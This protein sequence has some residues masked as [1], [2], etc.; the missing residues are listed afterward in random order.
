MRHKPHHRG[1]ENVAPMK[2]IFEDM[3]ANIAPAMRPSGRGAC[4]SPEVPVREKSPQ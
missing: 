2:I 4:G 1:D 3:I